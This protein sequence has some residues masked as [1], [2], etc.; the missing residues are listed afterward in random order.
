MSELF[1]PGAHGLIGPNGAGK[2]T[3][4]NNYFH[5]YLG[6][7]MVAMSQTGSLNIFAGITLG[8]HLNVAAIS[9]PAFDRAHALELT[10]RMGLTAPSRFRTMS[11]GQ[12]QLC[13]VATAIA[14]NAPVLLLDEP[15]NALDVTQRQYIREDLIDLLSEK[16]DQT[17]VLT[18]H[19]SEDLTGLVSDVTLIQ[20]FTL[21]ETVSLENSMKNFP[22]LIGPIKQVDALS[23]NEV[24][25]KV[26]GPTA[27]VTLSKPLDD[28]ALEQI[29]AQAPDVQVTYPSE[30]EL[31]DLL[32]GASNAN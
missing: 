26:L 27:A 9:Y 25:R 12:L 8:H 21:S 11:A 19:R 28:A 4:L 10:G 1:T 17:L 14:T 6:T 7:G 16:E 13:A 29:K 15:F 20:H 5:R 3:Y 2:T 30:Q 32:I 18:S 24:A 31:I 22:T 23:T